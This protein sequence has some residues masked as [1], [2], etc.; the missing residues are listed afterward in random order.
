MDLAPN[1]ADE[2]WVREVLEKTKESAD[3]ERKRKDVLKRLQ[4]AVD[5]WVQRSQ[6]ELVQRVAPS[7]EPNQQANA[8]D[9]ED[10]AVGRCDGLSARRR[11]EVVAHGSTVMGISTPQSD[12]DVSVIAP[13]C[14]PE[15]RGKLLKRIDQAMNSIWRGTREDV[16]LRLKA[17][18][19]LLRYTDAIHKLQCDVT[20]NAGG[21]AYKSEAI[22]LLLSYDERAV[23]LVKLVKL[24]AKAERINDA[25]NGTF[26][27]FSL[28]LLVIVYLQCQRPRV[29]PP[30]KEVLFSPNI[31]SLDTAREKRTTERCGNETTWST[32]LQNIRT[33]RKA[34]NSQNEIERNQK[35]VTELLQDFFVFYDHSLSH[36]RPL[37]RVCAYDGSIKN[38]SFARN[39]PWIDVVDPF[40]EDENCARAIRMAACFRRIQRSFKAAASSITDDLKGSSGVICQANQWHVVDC[41]TRIANMQLEEHIKGDHAT[42]PARKK[43]NVRRKTQ[44]AIPKLTQH[45]K[46]QKSKATGQPGQKPIAQHTAKKPK[47]KGT[48]VMIVQEDDSQLKSKQD[49]KKLPTHAEMY[50][51]PFC[52]FSCNAT[53]LPSRKRHKKETRHVWNRLIHLYEGYILQD[54]ESVTCTGCSRAKCTLKSKK[55]ILE[56]EKHV[57]LLHL[58]KGAKPQNWKSQCSVPHIREVAGQAA[59]E[60]ILCSTRVDVSSVCGV[61]AL[62]QHTVPHEKVK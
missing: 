10:N 51:C 6:G 23:E 29:L 1:M 28:V 20:V 3:V 56:F 16:E 45:D 22:G 33:R 2:A 11:L 32:L 31:T 35:L 53:D 27:T 9:S 8:V 14:N 48:L 13:L 44:K 42:S 5:H 62:L 54:E 40:D 7:D 41:L 24:W 26:N 49:N 52:P 47:N 39:G 57:R 21:S 55:K 37:M 61:L 4:K 15:D 17:R 30:L 36:Y 34:W 18:T 59:R 25:S 43:G 50:H 60:C 19:P 12:M 38:T 46:P 58:Y